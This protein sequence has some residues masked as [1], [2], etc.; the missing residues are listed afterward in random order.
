MEKQYSGVLQ[1]EKTLQQ[2]QELVELTVSM[3][4]AKIADYA[5]SA[6]WGMILSVHLI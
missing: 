3:L 2:I 6:Q 5:V 1:N 4:S